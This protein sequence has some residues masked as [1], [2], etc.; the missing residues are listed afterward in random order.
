MVLL[1]SLITVITNAMTTIIMI[2]TLYDYYYDHYTD[3]CS[4][5]Y[6][7]YYG[8]SLVITFLAYIITS[9]PLLTMNTLLL[10]LLLCI[11]ATFRLLLFLF[12]LLYLLLLLLL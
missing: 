9:I 6:Y 11:V 5:C 10:V 8:D 3:V 7:D 4:Y 2:G 1:F 12:L